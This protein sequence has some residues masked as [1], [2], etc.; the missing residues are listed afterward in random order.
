MLMGT[1]VNMMIQ[2]YTTFDLENL[3]KLSDAEQTEL[4]RHLQKDF[5]YEVIKED[6]KE[7]KNDP[8]E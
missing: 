7:F 5:R 6:D 1:S 8:D 3:H 4:L 2:R